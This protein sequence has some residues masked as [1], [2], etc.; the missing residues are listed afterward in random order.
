MNILHRLY[1]FELIFPI[2]AILVI[3]LGT[4]VLLPKN[5]TELEKAPP[6]TISKVTELGLVQNPLRPQLIRDGGS[7][8]VVGGKYLW[9]F[10]DTLFNPKSVDGTNGRTATA[11]YAEINNPLSVSE[12]LDANRAPDQFIPLSASDQ[13]YNN[14]TK[15]GDDRYAI[16]PGLVVAR[17][18][19]QDALVFYL[20]LKVNPGGGGLNYDLL[21]TGVARVA[22]GS[23]QAAVIESEVFKKPEPLYNNAGFTKDG[24]VYFYN[25]ISKSSRECSIARVK[26]EDALKRSAY[27]FW[28]GNTWHPDYK[29]AQRTFYGTSTGTSIGFVPAQKKYVVFYNKP[30]SKEMY[31][32]SS[33]QLTTGWTKPE[34]FYEATANNYALTFHPEL[35]TNNGKVILLTYY[36]PKSGMHAIRAV[37][38]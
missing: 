8:A 23:T 36:Q 30:F 14:T 27:R 12:P 38:D 29:K 13:A 17:P 5:K 21:N 22:E 37:I 2:A 6:L 31:F 25:C 34:K 1:R 32:S 7:A 9:T 3:I 16:W 33:D 24:F 10:G 26:V 15:K 35:S 20:R 19:K 11:G 28:D 18:N 4:L